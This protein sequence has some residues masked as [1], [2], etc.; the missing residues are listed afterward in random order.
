MLFV[1]RSAFWLAIGFVLVAPHGT[2]FGAA[3]AA[4]KDQAVSSGMQAGAQLVA[5]QIFASTSAPKAALVVLQSS[6][7]SVDLPMQDSPTVP[8]VFPRPRPAAMG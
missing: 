2:D 5:S 1:V 6:T 4:V 8:F 3:A 7:P